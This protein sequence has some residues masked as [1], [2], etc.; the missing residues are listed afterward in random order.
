[1]ERLEAT[2]EARSGDELRVETLRR[3]RRFKSSWVELAEALVRVRERGA[4]R[5]WGYEDLYA[6]CSEELRLRRSTVDK[7][8]GS[9]QTLE[10]HAP[11]VI[12]RD[13]VAQ[14]VPPVD[15][16][17]YFARALART[18][19]DEGPDDGGV[20]LDPKFAAE[21]HAAVFDE[22]EPVSAL[23]KRFD[24]VFF[25]RPDEAD[26]LAALERTRAATR[27]LDRCLGDV[28]DL[29]PALSEEIDRALARLGALL[30]ARIEETR[31]RLRE[32]ERAEAAATG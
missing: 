7:L 32:L 12:G 10:R 16:V 14:P 25:P 5:E 26:A 24:P 18:D 17:D 13:A 27:R 2:L 22:A 6:Y 23:R 28:G 31:A 30:E 4:Y 15:S 8:T 3:A 29:P 11:Q 19:G 1:M 21:L 9:F 20:E